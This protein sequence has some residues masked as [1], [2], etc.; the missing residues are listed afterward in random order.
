MRYMRI[1]KYMKGYVHGALRLRL[2]YA[3]TLRLACDQAYCRDIGFTPV[4]SCACC[5]RKTKLARMAMNSAAQMNMGP[6][7]LSAV[8]CM[9]RVR[10][11]DCLPKPSG[12]RVEMRV[13]RFWKMAQPYTRIP[14][15]LHVGATADPSSRVTHMPAY[16]SANH[17]AGE[18]RAPKSRPEAIV[19]RR[20]PMD[21]YEMY[22]RSFANHTFDSTLTG[23]GTLSDSIR[24]CSGRRAAVTHLAHGP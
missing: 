10:C 7:M 19:E 8:S 6:H 9:L 22:V 5:N 11:L 4:F 17:R 14:A 2:V 23:V 16:A 1:E 13:S 15:E 20:R 18:S 24:C 12:L 3:P 21:R